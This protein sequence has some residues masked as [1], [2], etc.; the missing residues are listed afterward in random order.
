MI[1]IQTDKHSEYRPALCSLGG[2]PAR[3][4]Y[5]AAIDAARVAE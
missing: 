5:T 4:G 3:H 2:M 1:F